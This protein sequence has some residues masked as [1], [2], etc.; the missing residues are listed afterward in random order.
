[1]IVLPESVV[2]AWTEATSLVWKPAINDLAATG[3]TLLIGVCVPTPS[4][5]AAYRN[6]VLIL[7]AERGSVL[8]RVPVPLGMWKPLSGGGVPLNLFGTGL[9]PAPGWSAGSM[10]QFS[11]ATNNC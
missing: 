8:Q 5:V 11:S 7:G 4:R 6:A 10:P 2:P 3:R 9:A 1:V